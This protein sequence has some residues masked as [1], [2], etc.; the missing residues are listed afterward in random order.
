MILIFKTS[1]TNLKTI[2]QLTP[3]LAAALCN[4]LWNFDLKDRDNI[5]RVESNE[6]IADIVIRT[7]T[8]QGYHCEE[9]D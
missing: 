2:R 3:H 6:N 7:F 9:I 8:N 5:F 4:A 1:V